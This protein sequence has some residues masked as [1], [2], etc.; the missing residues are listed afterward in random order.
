MGQINCVSAYV[1]RSLMGLANL[2]KGHTES[3]LGVFLAFKADEA[4]Q[5]QNKKS[6]YAE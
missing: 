4:Q 2:Q 3:E 1:F 6:G 5:R